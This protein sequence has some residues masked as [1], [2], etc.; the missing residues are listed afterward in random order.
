MPT[1]NDLF[2]Y[3]PTSDVINGDIIIFEGD[4]VKDRYGDLPDNTYMNK[5]NIVSEVERNYRIISY[6]RGLRILVLKKINF[7]I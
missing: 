5:L 3:L 2:R 7:N 4:I 6:D 1:I